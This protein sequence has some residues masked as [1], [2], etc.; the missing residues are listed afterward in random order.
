MTIDT[1]WIMSMPLNAYVEFLIHSA[2]VLG[3]A[4]GGG[5]C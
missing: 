4:L 2:R 5:S 1:W 3:W